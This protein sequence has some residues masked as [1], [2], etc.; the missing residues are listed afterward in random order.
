MSWIFFP[1]INFHFKMFS[2]GY[3][4]IDEDSS[5]CQFSSAANVLKR[6]LSR[7]CT[8]VLLRSQRDKDFVQL[9]A[10]VAVSMHRNFLDD[11]R[12]VKDGP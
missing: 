5:T 10:E 4:C 2:L 6:L 12:I 11:G 1:L 3:P 8:A 9:D 7:A